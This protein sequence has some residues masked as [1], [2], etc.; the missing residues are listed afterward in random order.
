MASHTRVPKA[1]ITGLYGALLKLMIRKMLATPLAEV[2]SS[3]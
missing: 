3:A 2:V 1:E